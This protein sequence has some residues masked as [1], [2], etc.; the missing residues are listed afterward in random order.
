MALL[1]RSVRSE[2]IV[3][4]GPD[5]FRR[6]SRSRNELSL[7]LSAA[8]NR[9]WPSRHEVRRWSPKRPFLACE[10]YIIIL[11]FMSVLE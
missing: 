8:A 4:P 9:S 6:Q 7:N 3:L 1:R 11:I 5:Y 2:E 10:R